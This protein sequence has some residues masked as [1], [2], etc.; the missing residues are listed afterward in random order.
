MLL[1]PLLKVRVNLLSVL[2]RPHDDPPTGD[3]IGETEIPNS[4]PAEFCEA[5]TE[6]LAV[7]L[8]LCREPLADRSKDPV[9]VASPQE[10]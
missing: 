7:G 5:A 9:L 6:R 1:K 10:F 8:R 3:L 2:Y 4:N